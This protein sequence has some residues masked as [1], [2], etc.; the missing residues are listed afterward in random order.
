MYTKNLPQNL[1]RGIG[2]G[3]AALV[4]ASAPGYAQPQTPGDKLTGN[5]T[6]YIGPRSFGIHITRDGSKIKGKVTRAATGELIKE[7]DE[8]LEGTISEDGKTLDCW[9]RGRVNAK[10]DIN[11]DG[12]FSCP[13]S[14]SRGGG[15][16]I[17]T[18][19]P[20]D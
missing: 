2:A 5:Y 19:D 7:G 15:S 20:N 13:G 3:L 16:I 1:Y 17:F 18:K 10:V 8:P 9:I 11:Y 4:L 14:V 6:S 12:S